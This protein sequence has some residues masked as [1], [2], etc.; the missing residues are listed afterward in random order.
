M[1]M[2]EYIFKNEVKKI[3]V[4]LQAETDGKA[5]EKMLQTVRYPNLFIIDQKYQICDIQIKRIG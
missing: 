5:W 3:S 1:N 2:Y 4:T